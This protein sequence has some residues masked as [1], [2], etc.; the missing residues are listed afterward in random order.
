[1]TG[2]RTILKAGAAGA[3]ALG[4][5]FAVRAQQKPVSGVRWPILILSDW[6]FEMKGKPSAAAAAL[7][8]ST[9][10]REIICLLLYPRRVW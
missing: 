5:P 4:F 9:L 8:F 1:M 6:A 7:A 10:L 3:L 2:R